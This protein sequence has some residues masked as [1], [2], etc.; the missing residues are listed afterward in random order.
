M[1]GFGEGVAK[2]TRPCVHGRE[3]GGG[4]EGGCW[5]FY[6]DERPSAVVGKYLITNLP[7]APPPYVKC[8][9]SCFGCC[10]SRL[11]HVHACM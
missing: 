5:V 1:S 6:R 4:G 9:V 3:R 2:A 10:I 7:L 8:T 11:I